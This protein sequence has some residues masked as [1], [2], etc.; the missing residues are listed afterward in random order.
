M[1]GL[2]SEILS[3]PFMVRALVV[4][5]LVS[6]CAALLGVP[7]V[8]KRYSMIGD[9]LSHI[10]FGA[11]ACAVAFGFAPLI[12]A[13]PVVVIVSFLLLRFSESA[14]VKGD[15]TIAIISSSSLA[16]GVVIS[17]LFGG[18]NIDIESYLFG[19]ILAI[20][21]VDLYISIPLSVVLILLFV[22]FYNRIFSI[23][24]DESF[25][26]ATGTNVKGYNSLLAVLIAL[27][28]VVGMRMLGTLLISS[29]IVFPSVSAMKICKSFK[30]VVICAGALSIIC[31]VM[32][33][34]FS[35][36]YPV[37]SGACIVLINLLVYILFTILGIL[38][39]KSAKG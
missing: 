35:Y 19:S 30:G 17:S 37:P 20:T 32:G 2:I 5:V 24:F 4:G 39:G 13:I 23:T 36:F 10:G 1:F 16:L 18:G 33:L 6:L 29:L 28:I 25:S 9:G 38:K 27:T 3:L 26:S 31:F 8:L 15:A 22:V 12:V 14:K 21:D 7:L 11:M 34:I